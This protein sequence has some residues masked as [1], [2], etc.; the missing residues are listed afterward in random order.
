MLHPFDTSAKAYHPSWM[1]QGL[2][3]CGHKANVLDALKIIKQVWENDEKYCTREG[4]KRCW[5][6]A[7]VLPPTMMDASNIINEVGHSYNKKGANFQK[8]KQVSCVNY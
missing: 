4:I 6:R 8:R 5:R 1:M 3:T 2:R 7:G